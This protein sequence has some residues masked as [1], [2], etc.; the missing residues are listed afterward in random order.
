MSKF[1][2]RE[3]QLSFLKASSME[4]GPHLQHEGERLEDEK[5]WQREKHKALEEKV[6][7]SFPSL[8]FF[9][10]SLSPT[11]PPALMDYQP[12]VLCPGI[13]WFLNYLGWL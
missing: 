5:N 7:D 12:Y 2:E 8:P 13:E 10:P 3:E 4:S 9:P 1:L 11:Y 6:R